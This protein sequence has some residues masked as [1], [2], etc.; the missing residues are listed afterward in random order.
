MRLRQLLCKK[1]SMVLGLNLKGTRVWEIISFPCFFHFS[2]IHSTTTLWTIVTGHCNLT[3]T[4]A[5]KNSFLLLI[6]RLTRS[7]MQSSEKDC[8]G[9]KF[10]GWRELTAHWIDISQQVLN[11]S[12]SYWGSWK[13]VRTKANAHHM[14]LFKGHVIWAA[15]I[16]HFEEILDSL[17]T[18]KPCNIA[19]ACQK[20]NP[21]DCPKKPWLSPMTEKLIRPDISGQMRRMGVRKKMF[22]RLLLNMTSLPGSFLWAE[23]VCLYLIPIFGSNANRW[24]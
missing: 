24:S 5:S 17:W 10:G 14:S 1:D 23:L 13:V 7:A 6:W 9:Q 16:K 19:D 8:R 15:V 4:G 18:E 2:P 21:Q 12:H 22:S 20:D 3:C 11:E